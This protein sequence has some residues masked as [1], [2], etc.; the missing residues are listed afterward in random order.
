MHFLA[1]K[2]GQGCFGPVSDELDRIEEAFFLCP[3][4]LKAILL[5][6]VLQEEM[7]SKD[8]A[9]CFE[10]LDVLPALFNGLLQLA[11]AELI[12]LDLFWRKLLGQLDLGK[13]EQLTARYRGRIRSSEPNG[14]ETLL[15][16]K[17]S[18]L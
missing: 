8:F 17:G 5:R 15:K 13:L 2:L 10:L 18:L 9:L 3:Q 7:F 14:Q 1:S 12:G 4:L 6:P 16:T 11:F